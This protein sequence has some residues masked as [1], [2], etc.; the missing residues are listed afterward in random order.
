MASSN[1][2]AKKEQLIKFDHANT[3]SVANLRG[4]AQKVNRK[5]ATIWTI[6][7]VEHTSHYKSSDKKFELVLNSRITLKYREVI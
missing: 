1:C 5:I 3:K 6:K 2:R 4:Q 7:W